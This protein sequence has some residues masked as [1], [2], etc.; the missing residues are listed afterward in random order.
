MKLIIDANSLLNQAL[1]RGTDHDEG[2]IIKDEKGKDTQVNGAQ[3]GVDGFFDKINDLLKEFNAA[4]RQCIIVWDGASAKARRRT[5]LP[6]YKE[7]RDKM[8]EVSEQLNIARDRVT[9]MCK[10]LGMHIVK[11]DGLEGDDVIGYLCKHL[12]YEKNV[13]VTSDGDLSVLH[14][15]NTDVWRLGELNKNPYGGFPHKYITL[16]KALVGDNGDKIPGAKG[17]GDAK[18]VD[19]VRIFGIEGLDMMIELIENDQL[20]RLKE[21]VA[22]FPALQIIINDKVGVAMSWRCARLLVE[23]VNTKRKPL[24]LEAGMVAQ[25][26]DLP[27]ELRVPELRHFYGTKTLVTASN[28]E[29]AKRRV[30]EQMAY[31]PFTALDIETSACD[32]AD[33][34]VEKVNSITGKDKDILDVLGHELTGMSL[35]FGNNTQHT[36]YMTVDHADSDN[37]TVDQCRE[38]V[39]CMPQKMHTVIQNRSFEFTVLYRTWGEKWINNGWHGFIPNAIDTKI[40]ATY[41]NENLRKGLKLRS[42]HHLGYKQATYAETTTLSGPVGTLPTGGRR[43]KDVYEHCVKQAVYVQ[44]VKSFVCE[45]TNQ[46]QATTVNGELI[47]PEVSE[48]WENRQYKMKELTAKQVFDYGCD[49]TIC[50]AAL[51][52]HYKLVMELEQTWHVYMQVEQLPE[53]LTSLAFIQ[54]VPISLA[55]VREMEERDAATYA[56]S[57]VTLRDYLMQHGWEGTVC[58]GFTEM[59]PAAVKE[60]AA[61]LIDTDEVQY[62]TKKRKLNAMALDMREQFTDNDMAAVL[63][64][65]VEQEDVR[66]LNQLVK[67][68]FTGEPKINFGSP[69]QLQRLFYEVIGLK[70]RIVNKMTDNQRNDPVMVQA[71]KKFRKEKEGKAVEWSAEER[72]A[73]ISKSS[74][75]DSAMEWAL[76]RDELTDEQRGVVQAYQKVRTIKTRRSLFYSAYNSLGH[77]SDGRIHPSLNQSEAVTLRYSASAPNVQQLPSRGEGEEFREVIQ[78]HMKDA[79]VVSLDFNGQELRSLADQCGDEALTACYVGEKLLDPHSLTAVA[80]ASLLWNREL[81]YDEFRAEYKSSDPAVKKKAEDLRLESKT[82]NFGTN[83]DLQAPGL[84]EQ[85]FVDESV[86]QAFIDAKDK[87]MPGI[88]IW[89]ESVREQAERDGF[90]TTLMGARRHLREA[91]MSENKWEAAKAGR[92][93]PNFKIQASSA[94]QTKLALA[95]M[96]RRGLFTGKYRAVFYFPVHDEVVF[97]VH[98]N[99]AV[100]LIKEVHECMTQPYG[101]MTIPI[102]SSI[103]LGLSFGQQISCGEEFNAAAIKEALQRVFKV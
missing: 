99:D 103:S 6:Q 86:A 8:P 40:G 9:T 89:K 98:K 71:F 90:V 80:A 20:D 79:V 18:F 93:G 65:V 15:A 75:D 62:T 16:Y 5:F 101:G 84:A 94:E 53:Y 25:W 45:E 11:Q 68:N 78:P 48:T 41:V 47:S 83:Y 33:E 52:T 87:A 61:L 51:H 56:A 55:K 31:T 10:H 66:T 67:D 72:L 100:A 30:A 43:V 69:K 28:Y 95:E 12:R 29:A 17:F 60:A 22:D 97:S 37:I 3:Y 102:I 88:N 27:D 34:W 54:G 42:E 7:G 64:N 24:G 74:T 49:D 58:P 36:I 2:R 21:D 76:R 50:T 38:M 85:L 70:P 35:T 91:L 14:D 13:V 81:T 92:Q 77:W 19:L 73:L 57:W 1:L 39:E 32:D 59:T 63:A 82:V 23:E 44:V 46:E 26:A 4:P 96:W